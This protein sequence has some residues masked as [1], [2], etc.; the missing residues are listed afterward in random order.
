MRDPMRLFTIWVMGMIKGAVISAVVLLPFFG[1]W[2]MLGGALA[3]S[4]FCLLLALRRPPCE[5]CVP[6]RNTGAGASPAHKG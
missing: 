2:A 3:F 5:S 1:P 4:G 6:N